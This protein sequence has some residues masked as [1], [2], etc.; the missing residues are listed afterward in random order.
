MNLYNLY[1]AEIEERKKLGL[2]PK[3]IDDGALISELI[4][5]IKDSKNEHRADALKY[6]IYNT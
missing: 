2:K 1:L 4:E 3:P 5:L 6:L